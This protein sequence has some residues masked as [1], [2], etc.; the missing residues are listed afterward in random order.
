LLLWPTVL[1]VVG[2]ALLAIVDVALPSWPQPPRFGDITVVAYMRWLLWIGGTAFLASRLFGEEF[3][4][5]TLNLVLA[6]PISRDRAW[7]AKFVVLVPI[8]VIL[9]LGYFLTLDR[10]L[11]LSA[12]ASH[13]IGLGL[14]LVFSVVCAAPLWSLVT[15]STLGTLVMALAAPYFLLL[16]ASLPFVLTKAP[17]S[18][19]LTNDS[20]L[21]LGWVAYSLA[22]L[23]IGWRLLRNFQLREANVSSVGATTLAGDRAH[24]HFLG[25]GHLSGLLRSRP[26]SPAFNL[27]A[28]E[29]Q[30]QAFSIRLAGLFTGVI[31]LV[32]VIDFLAGPDLQDQLDLLL[33]IPLC[34]YLLLVTLLTATLPFAE[35]AD[36]G[37]RDAN[38]VQPTGL[39]RPFLLRLMVS[40][41]T[42]VLLG[43]LLPV[44]LL[45]LYQYF[46]PGLADLLRILDLT[47]LGRAGYEFVFELLAAVFILSFWLA[48]LIPSVARASLLAVGL[49]PVWGFICALVAA[50]SLQV[51][52]AVILSN[53]AS[54]LA[55]LR[56]HEVFNP[57]L[58][59]LIQSGSPWKLF[60]LVGAFPVTGVLIVAAR[61]AIHPRRTDA[62]PIRQIFLVILLSASLAGLVSAAIFL[63]READIRVRIELTQSARQFHLALTQYARE[64][65]VERRAT[66]EDFTWDRLVASG[67]FEPTF[68][69]V[70]SVN[71][72]TVTVV[73]RNTYAFYESW[74]LAFDPPLLPVIPDSLT[75]Y[76]AEYYPRLGNPFGEIPITVRYRQLPVTQP[77]GD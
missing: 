62:G 3:R 9:T 60:G 20:L 41:G 24:K 77:A 72:P 44:G 42:F 27:F 6:Q 7:Q 11:S 52:S 19:P 43:I 33:G 36:W 2:S 39:R 31:L 74:V 73:R 76:R 34:A 56:V 14:F 37:I 21:V 38:L 58:N 70:N 63:P 8:V 47:L 18:V 59:Q 10:S 66:P 12:D 64:F 28:K 65:S 1:L 54:F 4:H 53:H 69:A 32:G 49:V 61:N 45:N 26:D 75:S 67:L 48:S 40:G 30:L 16:L 5:R 71:P 17:G 57:I 25:L 50:H 46:N 55:L 68:V 23:L 51:A 15:R 13:L 29:L 22:A 35:E